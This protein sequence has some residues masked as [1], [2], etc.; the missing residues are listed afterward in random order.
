MKNIKFNILYPITIAIYFPLLPVSLNWSFFSEGL[1]QLFLVIGLSIVAS[2]SIWLILGLLFKDGHVGAIL[3]FGCQFIFWQ[4]G[5]MYT[6]LI[7]QFK[8]MNFEILFLLFFIIPALLLLMIRYKRPWVK[9]ITPRLNFISI[10][11]IVFNIILIFNS[12]LQNHDDKADFTVNT[13]PITISAQATG[14]DEGI[15]PDIY[16][17]MVDAFPREDI[18][19]TE[20]GETIPFYKDLENMGFVATNEAYA[21][22]LFTMN[23]LS[24]MLNFDYIPARIEGQIVDSKDEGP[25]LELVHDNRL[26]KTLQSIGYE[27]IA[28]DSTWRPT[29]TSTCADQVI[30]NGENIE[31]ILIFYMNMTALLPVM[32][33]HMVTTVRNSRLKT[34]EQ[35]KT[36]PALDGPTFTFAHILLPHQPYVFDQNGDPFPDLEKLNI[37]RTGNNRDDAFFE[38]TIFASNQLIEVVQEIIDNSEVPPIILIQADHGPDYL[39]YGDD[40]DIINLRAPVFGAY[41]L[42]FGG[43]E[44]VYPSMS[45]VNLFRIVLSYYFDA[46][47][48]LLEDRTYYTTFTDGYLY[49]YR[50]ITDTIIGP[51]E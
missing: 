33:E 46:G 40:P 12:D 49:N 7:K 5:Y 31:D 9:S 48:E 38:Q 19:Q 32:N 35:I 30:E 18:V 50:D 27:Y 13:D 14:Y 25:L 45:P 1:F 42:P 24:A 6:V 39:D 2:L 41:Y 36:I 17:I 4:Y 51:L 21:N 3:T 23:A 11:F 37:F 26:C 16:F 10:I 28:L 47:L 20:Y 34:L 43:D 29:T 8:F 15:L 22:Y 44:L